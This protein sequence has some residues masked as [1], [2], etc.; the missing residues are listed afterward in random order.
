MKR[1]SIILII[2]LMVILLCLASF[3]NAA[4][5]VYKWRAV[6][7]QLV[8]TARYENTVV[9]FCEMVEKHPMAV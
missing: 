5:K 7:H 1:F 3:S 6:T 9:P 2:S 8:G 4:E